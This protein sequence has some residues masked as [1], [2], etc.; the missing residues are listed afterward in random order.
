M[1]GYIKLHRKVLDNPVV[2]KSAESLA[3]WI[4][5]LLKASWKG[6]EVNF[7]GKTITLKPGQL[8]PV[9]RK[10]I[11][12]ELRVSESNIQ[13]TLKRFESEHLIEQQTGSH[14]RLITIVSWEKYQTTEHQF[15]PQLNTNWTTT[16][17][18]LNTI[19]ESKKVI[20]IYKDP[21]IGAREE[22]S[23]WEGDYEIPF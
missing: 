5:L 6:G 10:T 22:K 18:Q 3:I 20:S 8:P 4:W 12:K 2:C 9:S 1:D 11:A 7:N 16:E 23:L 19:E 17:H 13:R 21:I 14:S 15:E